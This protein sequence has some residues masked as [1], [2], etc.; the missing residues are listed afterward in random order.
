MKNFIQDGDEVT[1]TAPYA[2]ASG[3]GALITGIFGVAQDDIANAA[4][5]VFLTAGVFDLACLSTD[6]PAVGAV[7]YWD[8]TNKRCTTTSTSNTKIGAATM[9]KVTGSTTVRVRL[10]GSI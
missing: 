10:N 9:V 1:L 8:D 7:I 6:T 2:V 5:G 3:A 4:S